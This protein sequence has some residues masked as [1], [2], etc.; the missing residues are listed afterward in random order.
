[1]PV[2]TFCIYSL[3]AIIRFVSRKF[4]WYCFKNKK[5][6]FNA[7]NFKKYTSQK[8]IM[9][10]KKNREEFKE[11]QREKQAKRKM[12][13]KKKNE[14]DI[15]NYDK[16]MMMKRYINEKWFSCCINC[17]YFRSGFSFFNENPFFKLKDNICTIP[18]NN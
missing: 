16:I 12:K 11:W 18:A 1:M 15:I 8:N 13:L 3:V 6:N 9:N 5:F 4:S 2:Y 10:T 7:N 17:T 14:E